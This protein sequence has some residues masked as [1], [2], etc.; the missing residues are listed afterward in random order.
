M[1]GKVMIEDKDFYEVCR[2]CYSA[3]DFPDKRGYIYFRKCEIYYPV[4][5]PTKRCPCLTCI[6]KGICNEPCADYLEFG[7]KMW[8]GKK[9]HD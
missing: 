8:K 1:W 9:R 7:G 6:V 4:Q 2:G 3:G 5:S